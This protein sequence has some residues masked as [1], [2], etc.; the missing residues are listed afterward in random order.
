MKAMKN[1]YI[2]P[3]IENIGALPE[4]IMLPS[5]VEGGGNKLPSIDS[6]WAR[7]GSSNNVELDISLD[8]KMWD[9]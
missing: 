6:E 3:E 5:S 7:Y 9:E 2:T 8:N 1:S 4:N